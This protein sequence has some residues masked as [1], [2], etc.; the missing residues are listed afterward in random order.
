MAIQGYNGSVTVGAVAVGSA[1]IWSLDMT[2][3]PTDVTTFADAGWKSSCGGLKSWRGNI[4]CTFTGGED[5]G[6]ASLIASF[7]AGSTVALELLTGATGAGTAEKFSGN[8][9]VT[10]FPITSDVN[11]CI[12]V[13]FAYEGQG[14]LTIAAL[15]V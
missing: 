1:S 14:A 13:T 7:E 9:V 12:V 6:E 8:A 5:T 10:G 4:T 3:D 2:A 11:G 15:P